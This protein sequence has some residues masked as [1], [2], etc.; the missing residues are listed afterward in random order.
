MSKINKILFENC[1]N[2]IFFYEEVIIIIKIEL[3][4]IFN[5]LK[6]NTINIKIFKE[7]INLLL[8]ILFYLMEESNKTILLCKDIL[9][10][11]TIID[12]DLYIVYLNKILNYEK[13]ILKLL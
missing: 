3:Y 11:D 9:K 6:N 2:D 4:D 10:I 8:G 12:N 1:N 13:I 5:K 7:Y